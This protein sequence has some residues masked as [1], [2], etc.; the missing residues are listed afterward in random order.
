[1]NKTPRAVEAQRK[2]DSM[3]E[4]RLAKFCSYM[5]GVL[6][7]TFFL[8]VFTPF[9]IS[10]LDAL[11]SLLIAVP[12]G[13][14]FTLWASIVRDRLLLA[15][16]LFLLTMGR[17]VR[18]FL[19]GLWDTGISPHFWEPLGFSVRPDERLYREAHISI[20]SAI[21]EIDSAIRRTTE[22]SDEG[23][24]LIGSLT[25]MATAGKVTLFTEH[26]EVVPYTPPV[27]PMPYAVSVED[28][29][30]SVMREE[31]ADA[32]KVFPLEGDSP[33]PDFDPLLITEVWI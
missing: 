2:E 24:A 20:Q 21:D 5:V 29:Q 11:L 28:V 14:V 7:T 33:L 1:M 16:G 22:L 23:R 8:F 25:L 32:G 26:Q 31:N 13:L 10:Q 17:N 6:L 30:E 9:G 19:A 3:T 15:I 18:A 4:K 27:E 12:A